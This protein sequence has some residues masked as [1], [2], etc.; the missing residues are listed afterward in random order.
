MNQLAQKIL[1]EVSR[2]GYQPVKKKSLAKKLGV[3]KKRMSAFEQALEQIAQAGQVRISD[4]GRVHPPIPSGTVLGI[5]R[6]ISSGSAFLIPHAGRAAGLDDVFID[7]KDLRDA[8]NGD[9]CLVRLKKRRYSGGRR[10]GVVVDV[11]ERATNVFVGTYFEEDDAGWVEIDGNDFSEPVWVGDPGA[12]GAANGDKVVIEMLR[13]PSHRVPGEAVLTKV[14]GPRGKPGVHTEMIIHEFGLPSDFPEAV[15]EEARLQAETFDPQSLSD[16]ED[17][18]KE[19]IITIDPADARDFDDAISLKRDPQGHWHLG[20][21]IADV[22]HFVPPGSALDREAQLRGTSVYLPTLVIPMLPEVI[23]NGLASLQEKKLRLTKSVFIEFS[24]SGVPVHTRFANTLIKTK[25]RF[26]YEQVLPIV[27]H[28]EQHRGKVP[29]RIRKLLSEMHELAMLLRQRRLEKGYLELDMP[30]IK[31]DFD[32]QQ[33]VV[34]AHEQPH[35]ESHQMIEEFMLAANIAVARELSARGISFL[36]RVHAEPSDTKLKQFQEMVRS[37]GFDL[38]NPRSRKDLQNL[39]AEVRGQPEQ[40]A[41][42]FGLLR[43][44]KQA[45]YSAFPGSHHALAEEDYCHFTSPIR[46]YPDL[47]IHRIFDWLLTNN[48][49][50]AGPAGEELLRLARHCS[51]TERRAQQAERELT[52]IKLLT[53]FENRIG[54]EMDAV[55]TGV[56]RYGFFVRGVEIPAEGLVHISTL[57]GRDYFDFD[58]PTM[59]IT[60]RRSGQVF[61]LGDHVRVK[62]AHVDVD[63]REFD[64]QY[65]STIRSAKRPQRKKKSASR[66]RSQRSAEQGKM[67]KKQE[68]TRPAKTGRSSRKTKKRR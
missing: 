62:V 14:L 32:K 5:I 33:R 66:G 60:G 38:A 6:K 63:R 51:L 9:E 56:D 59:S 4:S 64:L 53:Y 10:A 28:P 29:A 11:V 12:K 8:Q 34:G 19:L 50:A 54:M 65:V 44:M 18:T 67:R 58:R 57:S 13:F 49:T 25:R 37:L 16:R 1:N 36:R 24:A 31:L 48:P 17:L 42:N 45:E 68:R 46:R 20:V 52:K 43:S 47:T 41:I 7:A 30:E 3:T 61:R 21:H 23:S 2:P 35:D 22:A 55:I 27:E 15:Q 40:R 26:A 39:L